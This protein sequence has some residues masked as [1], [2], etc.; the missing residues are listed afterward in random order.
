MPASLTRDEFE[1]QEV[2]VLNLSGHPNF[3]AAVAQAKKVPGRRPVPDYKGEGFRWVYPSKEQIAQR[4]MHTVN[5]MPDAAIMGWLRESAVRVAD[6]LSSRLPADAELH[7]MQGPRLFQFQRPAVDFMARQRRVL[8]A[9]DMGLGKTIEA[10]VAVDEWRERLAAALRDPRPAWQRAAL[11]RQ[12]LLAAPKLVL[13]GTSKLGDWAR[14]IEA[15]EPGAKVEVVPGDYA[16]PKR[17]RML[18]AFAEHAR[19]EPGL[20][21]VVNHEQLRAEKHEDTPLPKDFKTPEEYEAAHALWTAQTDRWGAWWPKEAWFA[22]QQWLAFIGDE[23][24]RLK[25]RLAQQTRGAA[26]IEAH[27]VYLLTGTPIPNSP[28]ELWSPLSIIRPDVYGEDAGGSKGTVTYWQFYFTYAESYAVEGRGRVITGV[29]NEEE[30]RFE[31]ADKMVRRSKR[32][33]VDMGLLPPKLPTQTRVI[34]MKPDQAKLYAEAERELYLT[35]EQD[36]QDLAME[37]EEGGSDIEATSEQV[38]A[39]EAVVAARGMLARVE[40]MIEQGKDPV[41]IVRFLPNAA[42]KYAVLRQIATSPALIGAKD[43]SGKLD[44]VLED[45]EDH[46]GKKFVVFVWHRRAAEVITERLAK[47]KISAEWMHG[48]TKYDERDAI[49]QRFQEDETQILVATINTGGEGLNLTQADT[50]LFVESADSLAKNDQGEDRLW[51][52][53][54]DQQ[55]TIIRYVSDGTVEL[56]NQIPRLRMKEIIQGATVGRDRDEAVNG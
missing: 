22:E 29:K 32:I 31:L 6:E 46:P 3:R 7:S 15:W 16:A 35:I 40:K 18:E 43:S 52:L 27:L 13:A 24:H 44:G 17:R 10:I 23:A 28:D 2:L 56:E 39:N 38:A 51:R 41:D 1:G 12:H 11:E 50:A 33:L 19:N 49:I 54:Q 55:V 9:D 26:W 5:P 20:W 30:L 34:P 53:G 42:A 48:A 21:L 47:R 45:I 36:M 8:L 25:N 37:V 4:I 14:E